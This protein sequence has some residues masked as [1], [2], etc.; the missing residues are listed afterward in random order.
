MVTV[1]IAVALMV[2][3]GIGMA[4]A[5]PLQIQPTQAEL[6]DVEP[7]VEALELIPEVLEVLF[8][9]PEEPEEPEEEQ[10]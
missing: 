2:G 7:I 1:G 10:P 6:P 9:E 5:V 8:P 3:P 4:N